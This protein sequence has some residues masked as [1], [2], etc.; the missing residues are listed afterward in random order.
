MIVTTTPSIEGKTISRYLGIVTDEAYTIVG[1]ELVEEAAEIYHRSDMVMHVKE[2]IPSEYS[3][4]REGL[5]VFTYLHLAAD[6]E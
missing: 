6:P 1:A 4:L 3:Y 5:I 2:I